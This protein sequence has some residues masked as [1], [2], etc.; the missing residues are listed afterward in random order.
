MV[1][2]NYKGKGGDEKRDK[3]GEAPWMSPKS[4]PQKVIMNCLILNADQEEVLKLREEIKL[5]KK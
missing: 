3:G 5:L 1:T 4:D 2:N